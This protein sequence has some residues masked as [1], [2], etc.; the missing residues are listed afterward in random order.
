M[1]DKENSK[2]DP[3]NNFEVALRMRNFEI[4]QLAQRNNFLMVFQGVLFAGLVQSD[5]TK[6]VVSFM[7]CVA[8]FVVSF[9]Q[10]RMASGAKFWQTYWEIKLQECEYENRK[11]NEPELFIEDKTFKPE[12]LLFYH[13]DSAE[14]YDT[15][16][17]NKV[18]NTMKKWKCPWI[19]KQVLKKYSVSRIPI[20][21]GISFSIIWGLLV[22][23]TISDHPHFSVPN[24]I[25]GF[26]SN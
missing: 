22:L 21:V 4:E 26:P 25:V 16:Y 12:H 15:L 2:E 8:G 10:V 14:I 13:N 9:F 20:Y 18:K 6:P 3:I 24:C 23:C 1:C 5:H 17:K 7:V 19:K 11:K